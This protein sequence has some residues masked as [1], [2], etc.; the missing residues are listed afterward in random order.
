LR[1]LIHKITYVIFLL[2]LTTIKLQDIA[3][4]KQNER[5]RKRLTKPIDKRILK[6]WATNYEQE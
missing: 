6:P 1:L 3:F 4:K 5:R 2:Y